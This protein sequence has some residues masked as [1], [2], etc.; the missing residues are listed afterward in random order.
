MDDCRIQ[1]MFGVLGALWGVFV[2][3]GSWSDQRWLLSTEGFAPGLYRVVYNGPVYFRLGRFPRRRFYVLNPENEDDKKKLDK[4]KYRAWN[5]AAQRFRV[6]K[7]E[8]A[9]KIKFGAG[10]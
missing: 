3:H 10:E 7:K 5:D 2:L 9:I 4:L 1:G 6:I 8:D